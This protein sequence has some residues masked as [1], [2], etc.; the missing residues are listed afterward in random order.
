MT[1]AMWRGTGPDMASRLNLEDLFLFRR[2]DLVGHEDEAVGELLELG[3]SALHLVGGH[4]GAL[5]LG[6][7]LVVRVPAERADL[8]AALLHLLVEDLH[9]ISTALLVERRNVEADEV[10]VVV[11]RHTEIGVGDRLLDRLDEALVPGLDDD[12]PRLRRADPGEL[13]ERRVDAGGLDLQ[14]LH[15]RRSRSS[16]PDALHVVPERVDGLPKT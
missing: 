16:P 14:V 4:A 2:A 11:R 15:Q 12:L 3:L 6:L 10:A 7:H 13:D 8:H 1:T 5:L 9:Q